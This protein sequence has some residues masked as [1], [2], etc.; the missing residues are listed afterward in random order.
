M[1]EFAPHHIYRVLKVSSHRPSKA[2]VLEAKFTQM[3]QFNKILND[4]KGMQ[5]D[6]KCF[7]QCFIIR[8]LTL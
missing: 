1:P 6:L 3:V 5:W 7:I 8:E 4:I 2:G